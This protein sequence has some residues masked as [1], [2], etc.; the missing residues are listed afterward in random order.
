MRQVRH[1]LLDVEDELRVVVERGGEV[2]EAEGIPQ[3]PENPH[4]M[5]HHRPLAC[6]MLRDRLVP[7]LRNAL[8]GIRVEPL[9]HRLPVAAAL[10]GKLHELRDG[11]ADLALPAHHPAAV[12]HEQSAVVLLD[13]LAFEGRLEPEAHPR[14]HPRLDPEKLLD[15]RHE[16]REPLLL[17]DGDVLL[18]V[19]VVPEGHAV[20]RLE[21][22]NALEALTLVHSNPPGE[23]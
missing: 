6:V 1:V 10:D 17:P 20:D 21:S 16:R 13:H 12:A 18:P 5:K 14:V 23:R 7:V 9:A 3:K 8:L 22:H 4:R 11:R 15:L 2:L 19:A